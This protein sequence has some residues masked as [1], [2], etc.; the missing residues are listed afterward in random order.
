MYVTKSHFLSKKSVEI[1]IF[2]AKLLLVLVLVNVLPF[3]SY[4]KSVIL[5]NDVD[6]YVVVQINASEPIRAAED[7]V[8][9]AK[10]FQVSEI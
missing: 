2:S 1:L 8:R 7:A 9:T 4:W 10:T 3:F 5:S 6:S